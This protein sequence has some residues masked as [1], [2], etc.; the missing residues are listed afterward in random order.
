MRLLTLI[1]ILSFYNNLVSQDPE[2]P[3]EKIEFLSLTPEWHFVNY[4]SEMDNGEFDGFNN[5]IPIAGFEPIVHNNGIFEVFFRQNTLEPTGTYIQKRE[6]STGELLWRRYIGYPYDPQQILGRDILINSNENIEMICQV[7]CD[8]YDSTTPLLGRDNMAI[9]KIELDTEVGSII[10]QI[11]YVCND[12]IYLQTNFDGFYLNDVSRFY[13]IED[14]FYST[15]SEWIGNSWQRVIF[16]LEDNYKKDEVYASVF[17]KQ[18][19]C[20]GDLPIIYND[21][22]KVVFDSNCDTKRLELTYIDR[23]LEFINTVISDSLS[24]ALNDLRVKLYDPVKDIFIL[25]NVINFDTKEIEL[26]I[27]NGEGQLLKRIIIPIQ[28]NRNYGLLEWSNIDSLVL[29]ARR[30]N[31]AD[32][33]NPYITL[34]VLKSNENGEI[35]VAHSFVSADSL[36]YIS[37]INLVAFDEDHYY[38]EFKEASLLSDFTWDRRASAISMMKIKRNLLLNPITSSSQVVSNKLNCYPNP[39]SDYLHIV[40]L[41]QPAIVTVS[42]INGKQIQ[43]IENVSDKINIESL[44]SGMYIVQIR[45]NKTSETL[46]IIKI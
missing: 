1:L 11:D 35:Y 20:T 15:Q 26:L 23:D 14:T 3:F 29:L 9:Y 12:S 7:K 17:P 2:R 43:I 45:N 21:S 33:E 19:N 5:F 39:T 44:T 25:E 28:Y 42:D 22:T 16:K 40:N 46:K 38:L 27:I 13:S 24:V 41:E 37:Y 4:D 31:I 10:D 32:N 6:L 36:R 18:Y 34:D 8:P 30:T